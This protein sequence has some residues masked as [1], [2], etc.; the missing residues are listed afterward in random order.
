MTVNINAENEILGRLATKVATILRGKNKAS[1]EPYILSGDPVLIY[2]AEKIK[3]TGNK[4]KQKTYYRH[5]GYIGH[6]KSTT[7]EKTFDKNPSKVI[8]HAISGMLP[9]NRLRRQMLKRLTIIK[10][11]INVK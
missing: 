8:E 5:S 2:N 6:L 1:F 10:G 3:I 7:Y 9:K 11:P 4:A